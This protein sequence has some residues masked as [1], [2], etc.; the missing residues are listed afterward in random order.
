M[1]KRFASRR[2]KT[3]LRQRPRGREAGEGGGQGEEGGTRAV[4]LPARFS[5]VGST[6]VLPSIKMAVLTSM[7]AADMRDGL[8]HRIWSSG[9]EME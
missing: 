4:N 9:A 2:P 7:S 3:E 6:C 8:Y 1:H 5:T